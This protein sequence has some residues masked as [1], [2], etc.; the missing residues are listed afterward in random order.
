MAKTGAA[1]AKEH[2]EHKEV[3]PPKGKAGAHV[4]GSCVAAGC[5]AGEK[6]FSFCEEHY[7]QFKFGLIKKTGEAVSDYEKKFEHYQAFRARQR[8]HKVA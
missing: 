1:P 6:R 5:R 4:P 3:Q 8:A 7:E 2:T